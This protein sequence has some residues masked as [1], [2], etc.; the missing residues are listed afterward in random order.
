MLRGLGLILVW[1]LHCAFDS[2]GGLGGIGVRHD[3]EETA[4]ETMMARAIISH[5]DVARLARSDR[6]ARIVTHGAATT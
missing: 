3:G 1:S 2:Q 5:L 6:L 4:L